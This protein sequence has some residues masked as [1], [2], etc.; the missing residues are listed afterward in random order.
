VF[1]PI[2]Q[3]DPALD[4]G[5]VIV[6]HHHSLEIAMAYLEGQHDLADNDEAILN[7]MLYQTPEGVFTLLHRK[8][9]P[10]CKNH[11][12]VFCAH[13]PD[14]MPAGR[15]AGLPAGEFWHHITRADGELVPEGLYG[16]DESI[17][18]PHED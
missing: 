9:R 16:S 12:L 17:L 6:K 7:S 4:V 18:W 13:D 2:T 5:W 1:T 3:L 8:P 14:F 11:L 10:T 15:P